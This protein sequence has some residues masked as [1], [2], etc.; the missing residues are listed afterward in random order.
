MAKEVM[1]E[2]WVLNK[3]NQVPQPTSDKPIPKQIT[4][5]DHFNNEQL[6]N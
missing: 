4:S 1:I 2:I 6:R 5:Q 3:Q